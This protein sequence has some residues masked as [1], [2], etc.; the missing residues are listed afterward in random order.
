MSGNLT[1][2]AYLLT[3]VT[4]TEAWEASGIA[5]S[6]LELEPLLLDRGLW[7]HAL[8]DPETAVSG[9]LCLPLGPWKSG[10]RRV[11]EEIRNVNSD[12]TDLR[13]MVP[14]LNPTHAAQLQYAGALM[15]QVF[16]NIHRAFHGILLQ[17]GMEKEKLDQWS[18]NIDQGTHISELPVMYLSSHHHL[19]LGIH[20]IAKPLAL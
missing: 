12:T 2:P 6:D 3:S 14:D 8:C 11:C 7:D 5:G 1:K 17:H 10:K 15:R 9:S 4:Y 16:L 19:L 18:R 13:N 20:I